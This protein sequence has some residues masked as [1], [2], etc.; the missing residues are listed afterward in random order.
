ME[1]ALQKCGP[2]V[3]RCIDYCLRKGETSATYDDELTID[4][5]GE[6]EWARN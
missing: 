5:V 4:P 6:E 1:E 2:D 3:V